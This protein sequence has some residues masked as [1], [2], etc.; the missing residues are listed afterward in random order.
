MIDF[1]QI[2]FEGIFIHQVGNKLRDE[3]L[4]ISSNVISFAD[5][6][7]ESYL[8]KYFLSPFND[9]EVYNFSHPS[10]LNLNEIY[11]FVKRLFA[12]PK[13]LYQ[14]SIDISKH[15]YENSTHPKIS[16]GELCI[17][18]F[19]NCL[20]DGVITDAIGFFK[21]ESK[22]VFLKFDSVTNDFIIKHE[23]GINVNKLDKG[24]LIFNLDE[25]LGYKVCIIDSNKSNDTQ[26][27]KNDFLNIKPAS[28]S[29]QF[30]KAFL[31]ITKEFVT[32]TLSK[33]F[34]I[35]KADQIVLLNRSVQ[36]FK[37]NESFNKDDFENE[38]FPNKE[39]KKSFQKY[40]SSYREDNEIDLIENFV[41]SQQ[42]VKKQ[43]RIFKSVLKLDKNFHVYIHGNRELIEQGVESDGRKFYK[44]YFSEES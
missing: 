35:S 12:S 5:D 25:A 44:L 28:D 21:S 2:R 19:E 29:Y 30:T 42:A 26:Y 40:D 34:E 16:G 33:N 18:Y 17:C 4:K 10:E 3:G 36:Y 22:D 8:L 15:L 1:T 6:D 38:I 14:S 41:I 7:T 9:N 27:W 32:K 24:C 39:I 13:S 43:A 31:S 37:S 20:F 11:V 23:S